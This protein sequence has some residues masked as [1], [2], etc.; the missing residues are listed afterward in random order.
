MAF[1]QKLKKKQL[2]MWMI[3]YIQ[4]YASDHVKEV[5]ISEYF[6]IKARTFSMWHTGKQ[7]ARD[8]ENN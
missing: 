2:N 4:K 1:N 7:N 8:Q 6:K 5:T 3:Y